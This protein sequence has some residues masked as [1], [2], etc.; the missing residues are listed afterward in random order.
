MSV[1]VKHTDLLKQMLAIP[2]VSRKEQVRSDFLEGYLNGLGYP[3][4]RIQN[5]LLVGDADAKDARLRVLLNSHLDTVS[6][7]EGWKSDPF[8]PQ[9]VGD[10]IIGL[11][12]NDAGAS[13]VCLIAAFQKM[14]SALEKNLNLMLLISAEEEVSGAGGIS[15][16]LSELGHLD[17]VVVGEPTG[18]HPAVAERGLMVLDGVAKGRAGHAARSEGTNA[19]YNAINDIESI[20]SQ[21][22]NNHSHWLP[23]AGAQVTMI[24]AGTSHNVVPDLCRFVVDVRSNDK[25]GNEDMLEIL[26]TGCEAILTPRST[27]LKPSGLENNHLLMETIRSAGYKP[28]GSSTLSDMALIPFPSIKMGPGDS[29]R[30]HTAGEYILSGELEQGVEIYCNF[31]NIM[32]EI[33]VKNKAGS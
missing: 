6:P 30:S 7:V 28:F 3:V 16:V 22:F 26:R 17:A 12:S 15:S 32:N 23:D 24:E 11:G 33:H 1:E 14:H 2:A 5:N 21:K 13:V 29:A 4:T 20:S 10:K 18:M 31:L 27:R 25:Y 19:I 9:T 8:V